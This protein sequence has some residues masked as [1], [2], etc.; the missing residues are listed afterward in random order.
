MIKNLKIK[1][2]SDEQIAAQIIQKA[3][4]DWLP[5]QDLHNGLL[6]RTDGGIVGGV[7]VDPF[8]IDLKSKNEKKTIIGSVHAAINALD[9]PW[10]ILSMYRPVDLDAY[11]NSLDALT[12]EVDN[13]RKSLLRDYLSWVSGK[14]YSGEAVERRYYVLIT[15]NGA[16]AAQEHRINL[17]A[18]AQDL[19][20][21]QGLSTRVMTDA[22]W[23]EL[24]FLA[25]QPEHAAT[26]SIP[27]G[28]CRISPLY[29]R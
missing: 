15:R 10:Q 29:E 28:L 16:D 13:K 14:V 12:R 1:N 9:V 18:F 7:I 22:D 27:D 4:Q 25:F 24:L 23:R 20:R 6:F 19:Q 17:P 11:L 26:E 21:A 3:A 8:S 5:M 2:K